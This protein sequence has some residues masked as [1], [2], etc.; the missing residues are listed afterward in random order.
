MAILRAQTE[1]RARARAREAWRPRTMMRRCYSRRTESA[2]LG[3]PMSFFG[4]SHEP[5]RPPMS[6][7]RAPSAASLVS[8]RCGETATEIY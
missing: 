5:H 6:L 1:A 8:E 7:R 2:A 3:P 4:L